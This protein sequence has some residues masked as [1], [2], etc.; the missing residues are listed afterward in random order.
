MTINGGQPHAV[1]DRGQRYEV[2][3]FDEQ[4]KCRRVLGW[5][6]TIEGARSMAGGVEA[7]PSWAHPWI[8][9]RVPLTDEPVADQERDPA[10]LGPESDRAFFQRIVRAGHPEIPPRHAATPTPPQGP[11]KP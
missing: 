6:A 11:K 4:A 7:H 9:D 2:S 3:F 10:K 8:T 1:G 5:S